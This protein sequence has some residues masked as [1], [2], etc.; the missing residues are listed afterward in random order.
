MN[1]WIPHTGL[2]LKHALLIFE[3]KGK[4]KLFQVKEPR[5]K[6]ALQTQIDLLMN[7]FNE[8][9]EEKTQYFDK[10]VDFKTVVLSKNLRKNKVLD[11]FK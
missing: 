2:S 8:Y 10:W 9:T 3:G 5:P 1:L 4:G 6:N 7:E 11:K